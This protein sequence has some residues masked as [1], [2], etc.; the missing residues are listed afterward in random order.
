MAQKNSLI[1]LIAQMQAQGLNKNQIAQ[2]LNREGYSNTDIFQAMDLAKQKKEF[3]EPM[4]QPPNMP[5]PINPMGMAP[6]SMNQSSPQSSPQSNIHEEVHEIEE[7]IEQ[8]IDEKWQDVEKH[9][10]ELQ[11]WKHTVENKL[12]TLDTQLSETKTQFANLQNALVGKMG[13]YDKNILNVGTQLQ[14]MEMAFSKILP[15]FTENIQELNR[16]TKNMKR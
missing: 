12:T 2:N 5:P 1:P 7:L 11:E 4:Q 3:G 10:N 13:E 15:Q 8:I 6:T 9:F 16:I 14:A